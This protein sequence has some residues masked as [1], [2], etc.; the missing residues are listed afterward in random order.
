MSWI[1]TKLLGYRQI[2]LGGA[3]L[4]QR[5]NL[6]FVAGA[7]VEDNPTTGATDVTID[8]TT[9]FT[10]A[11]HLATPYKIVKRS[12]AGSANFG[13][14]CHFDEIEATGAFAAGAAAIN[15]ALSVGGAVDV[16]GNTTLE[17]TLDCYGKF[18]CGDDITS[19]GAISCNAE[20]RCGEILCGGQVQGTNYTLL[21]ALTETRVQ[22][23]TPVSLDGD[24]DLL[25]DM[26]WK[27]M[28]TNTLLHVPLDLPNGAVLTSV[29]VYIHPASGHSGLPTALNLPTITVKR[30]LI[31][32]QTPIEMP[33]AVSDPSTSLAAYEV[34]HAISVPN[35]NHTVNT[36]SYRYYVE[37]RSEGGLTYVQQ[38]QYLSTVVTYTRP[39]G[40][41]IGQ[42]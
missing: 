4:P 9:I 33:A 41:T 31:G 1:T 40:S 17:G 25:P 26:V 32:S 35:I 13:G 21:G 10:D 2:L 5:S 19:S 36:E 39:A 18:T 37:V 14:T 22:Q 12:I 42:D 15:G 38:C 28:S 6:N 7:K 29:S 20:M 3:V 11:T 23:G 8:Q 24:W 30:R 34:V 27:N 16:A